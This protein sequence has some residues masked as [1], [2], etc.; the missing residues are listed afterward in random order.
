MDKASEDLC[1]YI[2]LCVHL[3]CFELISI[4][5]IGMSRHAIVLCTF[6]VF[7]FETTKETIFKPLG[8]YSMSFNEPLSTPSLATFSNTSRQAEEE[9]KE[10][11][12]L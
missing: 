6:D 12:S 2:I 8:P 9:V 10:T 11:L 5:V 7:V 1:T 3:L 4:V